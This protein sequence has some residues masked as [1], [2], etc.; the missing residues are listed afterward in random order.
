MIVAESVTEVFPGVWEW[1][2]YS[3]EHRVELTSHAVR[4]PAGWLVFDPIPLREDLRDRMLAGG[5]VAGVVMTNGN[6]V[7]AVREWSGRMRWPVWGRAGV[8]YEGVGV[9]PLD[10]GPGTGPWAGWTLVDLPGGAPGETAF[11][12][13][14]LDLAVV[15][16]AV[17]NLPGRSLELLPDKYCTDPGR[18]RESVGRLATM[19]FRRLV[20]AHG[21]SLAERAAERVRGLV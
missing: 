11:L 1:E 3:P 13:A 10:P 9:Q 17:V 8:D 2:V 20:V 7:R 18:L 16:D 4:G 19:G 6:H 5:A 15:G 14:G 21:R 12:H